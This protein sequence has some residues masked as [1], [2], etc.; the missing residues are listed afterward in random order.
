MYL[1]NTDAEIYFHVKYVNIKSPPL[2]N[3]MKQVID[4]ESNGKIL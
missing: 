2:K 1:E 4:S 3:T